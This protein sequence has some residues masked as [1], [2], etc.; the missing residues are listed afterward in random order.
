[1]C[2]AKENTTVGFIS[3][4]RRGKLDSNMKNK[5]PLCKKVIDKATRQVSR[6]EGFYPFCS[7]RCKLIDLGK[8]LDS[9]YRIPVKPEDEEQGTDENAGQTKKDG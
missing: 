7:S 5:C 1:M 6:K 8:W 3:I 4:R 2:Q 9:N